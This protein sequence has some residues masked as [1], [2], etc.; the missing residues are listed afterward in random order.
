MTVAILAL[1]ALTPA[2]DFST[3]RS[4]AWSSADTW[5][6]GKVPA[7]SADVLIRVGHRVVYDVK[8]AGKT[9]P[10]LRSVHVAG[11]LV[12]ADDRS[13]E[14]E[15]GL[16]VLQ[17]DESPLQEA[18][19]GMLQHVHGATEGPR[20]LLQIGTPETPL[21][22]RYTASIRLRYFPGM[23]PNVAP[24]LMS[25]GGL[26]HL[27]GA[28]LLH[29]WTKL[30][31]PAQA[32]AREVKVVDG[33]AG[34]RVGD[35]VIVPTTILP[36]LFNPNDSE[37]ANVPMGLIRSVRGDS[38]TEERVITQVRERSLGFTEP[39][40]YDHRVEGIH[41]GEV[42]NL[43]RN[44]VIE[45]ADPVGG[46]GRWRG[47]TMFHKNSPASLSFVELRHLGK[48][49]V[50]GRYTLHFHQVEDSMRGSSIVGCALWDS[51]NRWLT[52]HGTEYLVVRDNVG[53]ASVGHGFFMEDSTESYNILDHNLAVGSYQAKALPNQFLG[54]DAN[55]GANFWWANS[56]NVFTRNVA[57]EGDQYGYRF[58]AVKGEHF[59]NVV[60]K[61]RTPDGSRLPIDV[62]TLPFIKF[63][64]NEVHSQ[65]RFGFNLG[66]AA[67][68]S[69]AFEGKFAG[70]GYPLPDSFSA[71]TVEGVG[72]DFMHPFIVRN[73]SVWACDWAIH[74]GSSSVLLSGIDIYDGIYG[75]WRSNATQQEYEDMHFEKLK[76]PA[77][78]HPWGGPATLASGIP[79]DLNP[80]DDFPPIT[81]VTE[82]RSRPDGTL[83]VRGSAADNRRV[84]SV[85]VNQV[86]ARALAANYTQWEI[87][88]QPGEW[89][90]NDLYAR[91]CDESGL[92]EKT[93][94][95]VHLQ[96]EPYVRRN[97]LTASD[98]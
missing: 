88:L 35:R 15:V 97:D 65:R 45:S 18:H 83:L 43:S 44:I 27:H 34:W 48:R 66:G 86:A 57:V 3:A 51:D 90:N 12:F 68:L 69:G 75:V 80:R 52:L 82:V 22:A 89:R 25:Q 72:P 1:L 19:L 81:V 14:L 11:S 70:F 94:H 38:Q 41:R 56:L 40:K 58:E 29:P 5:E 54:F 10:A 60:Q 39:L 23:D 67:V 74:I 77:F 76:A 46:D 21:A 16:L 59:P 28:P 7:A 36:T 33:T 62:R 53:Y 71:G 55:D 84:T 91:S 50:L 31:Q 17:A 98:D 26:V 30:D 32:G 87:I 79:E 96:E 92:E 8:P 4:G 63:A 85:R 49:N 47:H 78:Y 2:A 6:G 37:A 20:P 93:P 42:A 61:V 95:V 13:T 64:D 9:Q 24:A 73:L